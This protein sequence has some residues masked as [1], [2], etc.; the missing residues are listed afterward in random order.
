MNPFRSTMTPR[1]ER[2]ARGQT[3]SPP[4]RRASQTALGSF[5]K[6][7][8]PKALRKW[9]TLSTAAAGKGSRGGLT[10]RWCGLAQRGRLRPRGATSTSRDLRLRPP[11]RVPFP[12]SKQK[13]FWEVFCFLANSIKHS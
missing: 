8:V 2:G 4:F 10:L 1:A 13:Q 11:L 6:L 9:V 5:L 7:F 3:R 12:S